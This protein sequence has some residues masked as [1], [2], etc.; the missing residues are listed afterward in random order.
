MHCYRPHFF[1]QPLDEVSLWKLE[2]LIFFLKKMALF[3]VVS[4]AQVYEHHD[5]CDT[6]DISFHTFY[7]YNY[8]KDV[9]VGLEIDGECIGTQRQRQRNKDKD[10]ETEKDI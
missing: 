1:G 5:D 10:K 6:T 8:G 2:S 3:Q 9:C 7:P 4:Y